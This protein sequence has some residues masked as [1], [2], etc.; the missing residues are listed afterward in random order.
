MAPWG[1]SVG[2]GGGGCGE[3]RLFEEGWGW[4]GV[5]GMQL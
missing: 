3:L 4:A 1:V 5:L 2:N